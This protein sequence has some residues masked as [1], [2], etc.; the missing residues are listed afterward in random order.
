MAKN[1]GMTTLEIIRA[2]SQAAS[3]AYDGYD[4][5]GVRI[6]VG[7]KREEGDPILDKRIMDGFGVK[8]HGNKLCVNYHG[9]VSMKDLHRHGPKNFENEIEQMY[10]DI[11]KFLKKE[12]KKSTG[13]ALT[14]SAQGD[15]DSLIQRMNSVRN[16]V[17]ST[18]WYT[19]GNID[20][21]SVEP[22][23][24]RTVDDTIKK[25]L[26]LSSNKNPKNV[27]RKQPDRPGLGEV[28]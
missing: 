28:D 9:E 7:L 8:F 21:E 24:E 17:Q 19:I 16:W 13:S 18:K 12:Y 1:K 23:S 20:S 25:F 11:V 14:L 26:S 6:K 10:A 27:T 4:D 2:L 3:K 5:E 15:S 22:E